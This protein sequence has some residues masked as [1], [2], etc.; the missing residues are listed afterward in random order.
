[1]HLPYEQKHSLT[2]EELAYYGGFDWFESIRTFMPD[3]KII[4]R[5]TAT[6]EGNVPKDFNRYIADEM[7]LLERYLQAVK[8]R[9]WKFD[10]YEFGDEFNMSGMIHLHFT[11]GNVLDYYD[12]GLRTIARMMPGAKI[13]AD[14]IPVY[15]YND[16]VYSPGGGYTLLQMGEAVDDITFL[17]ELQSR[18]APFT[19]VGTEIQPGAHTYYDMSYI[20]RYITSLINLGLDV[21]IWEFWMLSRPLANPNEMER[22]IYSRNAPPAGLYR[23]LAGGNAAGSTDLF[24][25][26]PVMSSDSIT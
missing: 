3:M 13:C 14:I 10:M 4:L 18:K 23:A 24:L 15:A 9:G 17:S 6:R 7:A 12:Q 2:D 22:G 11:A 19:I 25:P 1:M 26:I 21:Y 20:K 5:Y 16:S 8:D